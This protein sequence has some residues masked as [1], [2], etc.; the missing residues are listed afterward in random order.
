MGFKEMITKLVD[1]KDIGQ[2]LID[3][4]YHMDYRDNDETRNIIRKLVR[5]AYDKGYGEG[6][7]D[8]YDEC[9]KDYY[10]G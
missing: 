5:S 2:I 10:G 1:I 8:G 7:A 4:E 9:G 3:L 6:K